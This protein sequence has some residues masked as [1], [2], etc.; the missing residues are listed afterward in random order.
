MARLNTDVK[1]YRYT[2]QGAPQM[3]GAAGALQNILY[4]C[5][6]TGYGSSNV[7]IMTRTDSTV[8]VTISGGHSFSKY[9]VIEIAG[10]NESGYNGQHRIE[11]VTSTTFTFTLPDGV[12]PASPATGTITAKMA[13]AGWQRPYVSADTYRAV[14]RSTDPQSFGHYLYVDDTNTWTRRAGA[15]GYEQ[16]SGID[17]RT[18]PFPWSAADDQWV[19]WY[20][21]DDNSTARYW[22]LVADSRMFYLWVNYNNSNGERI[23]AFGDLIPQFGANDTFCCVVQ[24]Q[25]SSTDPGY[26]GGMLTLTRPNTPGVGGC[27]LARDAYGAVLGQKAIAAAISSS[28]GVEIYYGFDMYPVDPYGVFS[29]YLSSTNPYV[30]G[31]PLSPIYQVEDRTGMILR[32]RLPGLYVPLQNLTGSGT[33]NLTTIPTPD[34]ALLAVWAYAS[35]GQYV[36]GYERGPRGGWVVFDIVGPWR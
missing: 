22:A 35:K 33:A 5:L 24:G 18:N 25:S 17:S 8:T 20:K 12:L 2:D 27:H 28:H 6:V 31:F 21:S 26:C 10:A 1:V 29:A 30:G 3:T 11:S 13:S 16:V 19:W 7:S 4:A 23:C 36:A 14:Y 15:K 32:G 34:G 9:A